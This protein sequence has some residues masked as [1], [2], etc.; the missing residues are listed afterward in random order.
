[1]IGGSGRHRRALRAIILLALLLGAGSAVAELA[2]LDSPRVEY[3]LS[4][5]GGAETAI[6]REIHRARESIYV[7]MYSFNNPRLAESLVAAH[8]RGVQVFVVVDRSQSNSKNKT[9]RKQVDR[10]EALRVAGIEVR[11][12]EAFS[13]WPR[14]GIMHLKLAVID[15]EV[16][17]LGS[18]NWTDPAEHRNK[19]ILEIKRSREYAERLV[20]EIEGIR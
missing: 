4:P 8:R 16:V 15:R 12:S 19:E 20:G 3:Y 2:T 18:Y 13:G 1:M 6:L 17:I 5:D 14:G 11:V 9:A 10:L 7:A